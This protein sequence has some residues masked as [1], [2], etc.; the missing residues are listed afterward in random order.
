VCLKDRKNEGFQASFK[1]D[2]TLVV[3]RGDIEGILLVTV[4]LR[5]ELLFAPAF[6][7]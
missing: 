1:T 3:F 7:F 6:R 2:V 5:A 4:F